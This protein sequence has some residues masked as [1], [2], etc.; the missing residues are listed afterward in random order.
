M[1]AISKR[2]NFDVITATSPAK[3]FSTVIQTS[4]QHVETNKKFF[5]IPSFLFLFLVGLIKLLIYKLLNEA[6]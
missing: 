6:I 3:Q 4:L 1:M 2:R 5:P